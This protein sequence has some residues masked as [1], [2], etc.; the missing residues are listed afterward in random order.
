M[1]KPLMRGA[2]PAFTVRF[3]MRGFGQIRPHYVCV[4][5]CRCDRYRLLVKSYPYRLPAAIWGLDSA[6]QRDLD[7]PLVSG[8][9][10]TV[11]SQESYVAN[12]TAGTQR[13]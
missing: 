9:P 6:F 12:L 4:P 1:P 8:V 10:V 13:W 7:D 2:L 3:R 11:T 5:R